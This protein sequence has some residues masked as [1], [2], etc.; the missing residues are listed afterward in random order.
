M[1]ILYF[2]DNHPF[3]SSFIYQD[4]EAMSKNH[5]VHCLILRFESNQRFSFK[6]K[7]ISY[8]KHSFLSKIK[9]KL[10]QNNIYLNWHNTSFRKL[11]KYIKEINPD[12]IHCQFTISIKLFDNYKENQIPIIINFRHVTLINCEIENT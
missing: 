4:V 7:F 3:L 11:N 6:T 1:R 9:W 8:P 5:E 12:I 10:E 2:S